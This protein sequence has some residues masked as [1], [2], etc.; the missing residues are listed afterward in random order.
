MVEFFN[1]HL[2]TYIKDNF[3]RWNRSSYL[4][5]GSIHERILAEIGGALKLELTSRVSGW[6]RGERA[7]GDDRERRRGR[8]QERSAR[9]RWLRRQVV[10]QAVV[11]QLVLDALNLGIR[12][13]LFNH[14]SGDYLF[15]GRDNNHRRVLIGRC[16]RRLLLVYRSSRRHQRHVCFSLYCSFH[17]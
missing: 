9:R 4:L 3:W 11:E 12:S 10:S 16:S 15:V 13:R 7:H 17:L 5:N 2:K 1:Y 8:V 14:P 6:G